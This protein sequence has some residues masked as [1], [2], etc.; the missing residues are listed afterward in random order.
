MPE[1]RT[2]ACDVVTKLL[3]PICWRSLLTKAESIQTCG[4]L[5]NH[6]FKTCIKVK[7][8]KSLCLLATVCGLLQPI[9]YST[10]LCSYVNTCIYV[11]VYLCI[12]CIY[13]SMYLHDIDIYVYIYIYIY[14][15][16]YTV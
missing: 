6:L 16:M 1:G 3:M 9:M 5:S 13:V 12:Y 11:Y 15:N 4:Q 10:N 7:F 14:T 8:S 2:S